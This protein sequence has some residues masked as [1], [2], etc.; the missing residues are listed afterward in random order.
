MDTVEGKIKHPIFDGEIGVRVNFIEPNKG[1]WTPKPTWSELSVTCEDGT[2]LQKIRHN[3]TKFDVKSG[4][5]VSIIWIVPK[6]NNSPWYYTKQK[7]SERS[8][9]EEED[10]DEGEGS[11]AEY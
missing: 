9:D 2:I 8:L 1:R 5:Q 4:D 3:T 6:N 7:I 11:L 10:S